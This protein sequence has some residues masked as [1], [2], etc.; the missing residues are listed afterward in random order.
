M[1]YIRNQN[2]KENNEKT[3][4]DIRAV[5]GRD[6]FRAL[7]VALNQQKERRTAMSDLI[8]IAKRAADMLHTVDDDKA[9]D[10]ANE[11][12][13]AINELLEPVPVKPADI[14]KGFGRALRKAGY[15]VKE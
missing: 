2:K 4:I 10:L 12:E 6:L 8:K 11:L 1:H 15:I 14:L 9:Q 5:P 7:E 13:T 3:Q